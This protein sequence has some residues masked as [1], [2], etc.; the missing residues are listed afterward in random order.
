MKYLP[1]LLAVL[2]V[3]AVGDDRVKVDLYSESLW[4]ACKD[5][6]SNSFNTALQASGF[7]DMCDL[8]IWPFGNA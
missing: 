4:P 3:I 5:V 7:L 1:L 6:M 2:A 8:H